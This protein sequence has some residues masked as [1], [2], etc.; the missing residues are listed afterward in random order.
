MAELIGKEQQS[1]SLNSQIK[2]FHS[3]LLAVK[4]EPKIALTEQEFRLIILKVTAM[5][6]IKESGLPSKEIVGLCMKS[7]EEKFSMHMN[8]QELQLAFEMNI[9]GDFIKKVEHYQQ[10]SRE[11]FCDVLLQ[12][13]QKKQE[14]ISKSGQK[15]SI[16]LQSEGR[17]DFHIVLMKALIADRENISSG[18]DI[19]IHCTVFDRLDMMEAL[20]PITI[21]ESTIEAYRKNAVQTILG[22]LS[23]KKH[24]AQALRKL[25]REIELTHQIARIKAQKLITENDE[26]LIQAEVLKLI[27]CNQLMMWP[28]NEF[29]QHIQSQL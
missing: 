1:S 26:S 17:E 8:K 15:V 20:F 5:H 11:F 16:E 29:I 18:Q 25:G 3:K 9:N 27:Y 22:N 21:N 10:F 28:E 19:T 4:D 6:G 2:G 24:E 12:Y 13:L 23:K 14:T 7:W